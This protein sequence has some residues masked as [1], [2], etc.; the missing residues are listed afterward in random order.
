MKALAKAWETKIKARAESMPALASLLHYQ[1]GYRFYSS[2]EHSD[3]MAI[4]GYV[5]DRDKPNY[6]ITGPSDQYLDIAL[7]HNFYVMTDL[8]G[9]L[10]QYRHP[11]NAEHP[12]SSITCRESL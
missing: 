6:R 4:S 7:A 12:A 2:I 10:L 8:F 9:I 11:F 5:Q 3:V 1:Q